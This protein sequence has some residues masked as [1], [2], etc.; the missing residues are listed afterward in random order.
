MLSNKSSHGWA[1][2]TSSGTPRSMLI[3]K[4][5]N[6]PNPVAT[7]IIESL[8]STKFAEKA[9]PHHLPKTADLRLM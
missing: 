6:P 1:T 3:D 2:N 5:F 9:L 4:I 7:N 8:D